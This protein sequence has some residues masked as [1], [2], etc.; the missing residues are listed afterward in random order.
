M[1]KVKESDNGKKFVQPVEKVE[2]IC[3]NFSYYLSNKS[4]N[5]NYFKKDITQK[6]KAYDSLV[7][8]L[9]SL[10]GKSIEEVIML[11]KKAGGSEFIQLKYFSQNFRESAKAIGILSNDSS[12]IVFRFGQ[13]D[14]YRLICK[15]DATHNNI[16]YV[17]GFDFDFSA[18]SH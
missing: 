1:K 12:L 5:F 9:Y 10:S 15:S 14:K 13:S 6:A 3:F 7:D 18:Y 2:K 16:L 17:I 4:Y 8:K 11:R